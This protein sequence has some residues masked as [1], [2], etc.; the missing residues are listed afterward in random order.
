MPTQ[1]SSRM[2]SHLTGSWKRENN[3]PLSLNYHD[4]SGPAPGIIN[5]S[6][7]PVLLYVRIYEYM[8]NLQYV[9][10]HL[11][12]TNILSICMWS[13]CR[14]NNVKEGNM[15][16]KVLKI[17]WMEILERRP[18]FVY[19]ESFIQMITLKKIKILV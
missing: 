17:S 10:L 15:E 14:N 4:N 12:I 5:A 8:D 2:L 1:T 13:V 18:S 16:T 3:V 9:I 11:R 7:P 19:Q 6:R